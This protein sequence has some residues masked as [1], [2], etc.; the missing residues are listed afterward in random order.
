MLMRRYGAWHVA[1][2]QLVTPGHRHGSV[3]FSSIGVARLP[4]IFDA[5]IKNRFLTG[6]FFE[7]F[8]ILHDKT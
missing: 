1:H 3:E 5:V 7:P 2:D 4:L 6:N 8:T